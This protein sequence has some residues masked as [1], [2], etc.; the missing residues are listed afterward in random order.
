M[1]LASWFEI[2]QTLLND[3]VFEAVLFEDSASIQKLVKVSACYIL[4][5]V[6]LK[7][8]SAEFPLSIWDHYYLQ[9]SIFLK[10]TGIW[11]KDTSLNRLEKI[12]FTATG[13]PLRME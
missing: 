7:D 6:Q 5:N 1:T 12:I 10:S 3:V 4:L 11:E 8:F 9:R 13:V 2:Y